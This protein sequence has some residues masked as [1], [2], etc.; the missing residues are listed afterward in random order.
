MSIKSNKKKKTI[1][2]ITLDNITTDIALT[3]LSHLSPKDLS[4]TASVSTSCHRHA[5]DETLW[6]RFNRKGRISYIRDKAWNTGKAIESPGI[7]LENMK[8]IYDIRLL[9]NDTIIITGICDSS[10]GYVKRINRNMIVIGICSDDIDGGGCNVRLCKTGYDEYNNRFY[11]VYAVG[12]NNFME[13]DDELNV[14]YVNL[15]NLKLYHLFN[16]TRNNITAIGLYMSN[17]QAPSVLLAG[18]LQGN[19]YQSRLSLSLSSQ[20]LLNNNILVTECD[21]KITSISNCSTAIIGTSGGSIYQMD[22]A[23]GVTLSTFI[24]PCPCPVTAISTSSSMIIAGVSHA[25][26]GNGHGSLAVAWD[27]RSKSRL[28]CFGKGGRSVCQVDSVQSCDEGKRVG[29]LLGDGKEVNVFDVRSWK[30]MVRYSSDVGDIKGLDINHNMVC[31]GGS[32][33]IKIL[34]FHDALNYMPNTMKSFQPF[35]SPWRCSR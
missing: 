11:I 13:G 6:K 24:G 30:C 9:S 14:W 10:K 33:C 2:E 20:P 7:H 18:N 23:T 17:T 8:N 25:T 29:V 31:M 5:T 4:S 16:T 32:N 21:E 1:N 19:L 34:N 27:L 15:S 28:G 26:A 22:A 35:D 12:S 3:I